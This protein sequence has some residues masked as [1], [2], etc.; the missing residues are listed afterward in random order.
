MEAEERMREEQQA[1]VELKKMEEQD[2]KEKEQLVVRK[3]E[4][5]HKF[6]SDNASPCINLHDAQVVIVTG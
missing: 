3:Q 5:Y 2:K 4:A 6:R 1:M